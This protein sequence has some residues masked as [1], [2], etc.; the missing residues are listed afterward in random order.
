[1]KIAILGA[2]SGACLTAA[3]F[4]RYHK[5]HCE[6]DIYHTKTIPPEPVGQAALLLSTNL[7]FETYGWTW[8]DNPIKAVFKTGASYHGWGHKTEDFIHS[9]PMEST[10]IHFIP[11]YIT[12]HVVNIF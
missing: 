2:G 5:E 4:R 12:N 8:Y 11:P 1:M 7:F 6:I 9:F 10:G 3:F